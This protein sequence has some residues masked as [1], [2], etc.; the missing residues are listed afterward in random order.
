MKGLLIK[1]IRYLIGQ[2]A[3][4]AIFIGL[5]LY[6]LLT[7]TDVSFAMVFS[8][9][10]AAVF[11]TSSISYD[12]YENGMAI[13]NRKSLFDGYMKAELNDPEG[14]NRPQNRIVYQQQLENSPRRK[15]AVTYNSGNSWEISLLTNEEDAYAMYHVMMKDGLIKTYKPNYIIFDWSTGKMTTTPKSYDASTKDVLSGKEFLEWLSKDVQSV[16]DEQSGKYK[17]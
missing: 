6:F 13:P 15:T 9:I 3:S 12:N 17:Y 16:I 4:I 10:M 11:S 5:G 2:K 8:M 14:M 1:D 7:E